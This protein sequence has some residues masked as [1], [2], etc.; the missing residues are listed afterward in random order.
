MWIKYVLPVLV[1]SVAVTTV[2]SLQKRHSHSVFSG[3]GPWDLPVKDGFVK[4]QMGRPS[5]GIPGGDLLRELTCFP[6]VTYLFGAVVMFPKVPLCLSI[7]RQ[8]GHRFMMVPTPGPFRVISTRW[9]WGRRSPHTLSWPFICPG[10]VFIWPPLSGAWIF[11]HFLI[12]GLSSQAYLYKVGWQ[13]SSW[14]W[15]R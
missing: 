5:M 9:P 1:V 13:A 3:W 7:F 11:E 14:V 6:H 10:E 12:Y 15:G 2:Q 8:E 4:I